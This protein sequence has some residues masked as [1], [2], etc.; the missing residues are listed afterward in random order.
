M[1]DESA[2]QVT[3]SS[4]RRLIE[5]RTLPSGERRELPEWPQWA[6]HHECLGHVLHRFG[7]DAWTIGDAVEGTQVFGATGSGKTSGSGRALAR[8]FIRNGFGGLVLTAKPDD[9]SQWIRYFRD[10]GATD[11]QICERV[12]VVEPPG[13]RH[14]GAIWPKRNVGGRQTNEDLPLR[15]CRGFNFLEYEYQHNGGLTQDIVSLFL[16]SMS[17]GETT[18][19]RTEP[20]WEEALRELLTHA[21]DLAVLGTQAERGHS[22]IRLSDLVGVIRSAA[23]KREEASSQRWRS[24]GT[25]LC[26]KFIDDGYRNLIKG[27]GLKDEG[28]QI[29][30]ESTIDYWMNDFPNLSDRTRSIITSSFTAK[31]AGLLR[32]PL[33]ELLCGET[34][35]NVDASPEQTHK[36]TMVIVNLPVKLYGE[37]GQFAQRIWKTMWQRATQRRTKLLESEWS[38]QRPVFLWADE[39]QYFITREDALF[40][41][42]ARSA[43]AATVY[44]TQNIS[45]YYV[46]LGGDQARAAADSL[47]GNLQTK[48]FHANGD[49]ETNLWAERVF[50]QLWTQSTTDSMSSS[51]TLQ[52][53]GMSRTVGDSSQASWHRGPAVEAREFLTLA[54]GSERYFYDVESI[55]LKA[56]RRWSRRDEMNRTVRNRDGKPER[57]DAQGRPISMLRHT[58]NQMD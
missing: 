18:V 53:S 49:P 15:V 28:R 22:R 26:W 11:E 30:L 17:S 58:F 27:N 10:S 19:S 35:K 38:S 7:D 13:D 21:V 20:Y 40:Q 41:Q 37:V 50:G 12:I 43:L 31:A 6:G 46:A 33:R 14:P 5:V 39:S 52:E 3:D 47:L 34:D 54:T 29:D 25:S 55:V 2:I 57:Q 45:N 16:T 24:P 48:V 51:S 42:T 32:K 4:Q 1:M 8:E 44:L 23:Q 9:L 56:G 36:G